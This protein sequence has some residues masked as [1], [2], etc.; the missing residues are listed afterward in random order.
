MSRHIKFSNIGVDLT[1]KVIDKKLYKTN[2]RN[3]TSIAIHCSASPQGRGDDASTIDRWHLEK[4]WSG[5]GYHYIIL[6]DGTILKG[7]WVDNSGAHIKGN[8]ATTIAI[9]RI[10]G[11]GKD[12][13]T[14]R[15]ATFEQ[16]NSIRLLSHLL[17]E[18][19]ELDI[20]DIKGHNEYP[21]VQ[22]DCPAMNMDFIRTKV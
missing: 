11:L 17:V 10:G 3:I 8:N 22:K 20:S 16:I 18:M 7:R 15:D 4:G 1:Q 14:I 6:E 5:I 21:G 12:G 2:L 13:K 19:Y 9:C